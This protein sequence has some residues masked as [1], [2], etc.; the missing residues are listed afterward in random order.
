MAERKVFV[1]FDYDNDRRYKHLLQAWSANPKFE[2]VF[3]DMTPG[4]IDTYD[5]G[6]IKAGLTAKIND[7]D[8]TLVIVGQYANSLHRHHE[9]IGFRNWINFEVH[10]SI[11]AGNRIGVVRLDANYVTP[12]QLQYTRYYWIT[13]FT[14]Q[15]VVDVLDKAATA[16]V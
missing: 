15:N 5:I 8:Y 14:E 13:G 1:S 10:Q 16:T 6:R 3:R 11:E 2:F 12:E 9:L 7:S 4:E